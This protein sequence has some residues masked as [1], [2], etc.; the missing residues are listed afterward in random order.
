M[1]F[2]REDFEARYRELTASVKCWCT[3]TTELVGGQP[4]DAA[5][6]AR[7]VEHQLKLTGAEAEEAVERILGQEIDITQAR[8]LIKG[9]AFPT[10]GE[11]EVTPE[12]A[13][14][15]EVLSYGVNVLRR[16]TAGP[17]VGNWMVKACW[18]QAASRVGLFIAQRGSKGNMA[19]A[20]QCLPIDDSLQNPSALDQI[21]LRDGNGGPAK[22][23]WRQFKGRVQS[24]RGAASIVHDS[25]CAPPGTQFAFEF[26][27][28]PGKLKERDV[29][30]I[31]AVAMVCGLG[32]AKTFERGKFSVDRCELEFPEKP[33][34]EE[35]DEAAEEQ[36]VEKVKQRRLTENLQSS[37]QRH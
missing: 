21:Y 8:Q 5:G 18:K 28:I 14:I 4:A 17:F 15:K 34:K 7:F 26:R 35:K 1:Q 3:F 2:T 37:P 10:V 20:G 9:F 30:D 22:T 12:G 29:Q 6:I 31:L 25:E 19:E 36:P 24:P 13:E 33:K 11:R 32:S 16:S 27:F 23:F